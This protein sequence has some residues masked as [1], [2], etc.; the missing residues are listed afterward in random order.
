MLFRVKIMRENI[1]LYFLKFKILKNKCVFE[2]K[3]KNLII[4]QFLS[5]R[6]IDNY[7]SDQMKEISINVELYIKSYEFSIFRDFFWIFSELISIF[8]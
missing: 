2:I 3:I 7:I 5:F 6:M 8:K 4:Y 1:Y